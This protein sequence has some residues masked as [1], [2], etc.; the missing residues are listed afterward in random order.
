MKGLYKYMAFALA[1]VMGACSQDD[2]PNLPAQELSIAARS[3]GGDADNSAFTHDFT[4]ELWNTTDET[5]HE[6]HDMIYSDGWNKVMTDILP[7][8]AFAYKGT[9]VTVTSPTEYTLQLMADQSS[10]ENLEDADVMIATG[11]ATQD[12]PL[13]LNFEHCFAKVS[14]SCTI[15]PEFSDLNRIRLYTCQVHTQPQV[16]A[17]VNRTDIAAILVPGTYAAGENFLTI[18]LL[19]NNYNSKS[20]NVVVP[21]NGLTFEAGK[22]YKFSLKIGKD[23]ITIEKAILD[24]GNPFDGG[25]DEESKLE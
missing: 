4:L 24:G 19:Y 3:T 17:Y 13:N 16:T 25:W 14:F 6:K 23:K 11:E 10:A 8:R 20:V 21:A 1:F 9:G 7:A 18:R 5:R 22:H 15:A 2:A 12:N